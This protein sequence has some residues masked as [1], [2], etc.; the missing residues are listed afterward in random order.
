MCYDHVVE[1]ELTYPTDHALMCALQWF[2]G[3]SQGDHPSLPAKPGPLVT[4]DQA[5]APRAVAC[6]CPVSADPPVVGVSQKRLAP[7]SRRAVPRVT[8]LL[9]RRPCRLWAFQVWR[10]QC[11]LS[12]CWL[13]AFPCGRPW[14]AGVYWRGARRLCEQRRPVLGQGAVPATRSASVVRETRPVWPS[15][16]GLPLLGLLWELGFSSGVCAWRP[17]LPSREFACCCFAQLVTSGSLTSVGVSVAILPLVASV[18]PH[19]RFPRSK[20]L[21]QD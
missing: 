2:S 6:P 14:L 4:L 17:R 19:F 12:A 9:Q 7:L 3:S 11:S 8:V 5:P 10:A 16:L 15:F 13:G 21:F 1:I 20:C 18:S